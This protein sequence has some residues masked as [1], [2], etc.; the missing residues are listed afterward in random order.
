[1]RTRNTAG[2]VLGALVL[3]FSV[4]APAAAQLHEP[5]P[6]V[7]APPAP[8]EPTFC[9]PGAAPL[10]G[11]NVINGTNLNDVLVGTPGNDLIR[12]FGGNDVIVGNEGNDLLCGGRG[13][14]RL[15]GRRGI[16][17]LWGGEGFDRLYG[18]GDTDLCDGGPGVDFLDA[19]TCEVQQNP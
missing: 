1:M 3:G 13:D 5:G 6:G 14:D 10:P 11:Y 12:G 18:E 4:I 9:Q 19:V 16:D 15:F 8:A 17:R 7:I 2:A